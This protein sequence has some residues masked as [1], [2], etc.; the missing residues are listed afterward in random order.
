MKPLADADLG[1][2]LAKDVGGGLRRAV[3]AQDAHV[4]VPIIGGALRLLVPGRRLPFLWQ[5]VEAVPMDA[6]RLAGQK[7][8]GLAQPPFLHLLGT[9]GR[10]PDLGD[11]D[12]LVG[13]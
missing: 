10:D 8:S 1:R 6:W 7:L 4:E 9:E 13:D 11:P 2:E 12:R 5:V 3:L